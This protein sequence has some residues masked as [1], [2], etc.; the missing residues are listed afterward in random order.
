M[1]ENTP[2]EQLK[3]VGRKTARI[4]ATEKLTGQAIYV[5]DMT[6]S[7][8]LYA[9]VKTSPHAR[10]KIVKI[11]TSAAE[12]LPGVRAVIT[13]DELEYKLGL[14]VVDKDI[15]AKGVVRHYGEAV[16]AVADPLRAPLP[17]AAVL[18]VL[19]PQLVAPGAL[20][21]GGVQAVPG[22]YRVRQ[23]G[24]Q[25]VAAACSGG[26][27]HQSVLSLPKISAEQISTMGPALTKLTSQFGTGLGESPRIW[28][29]AS[30]TRPRPCI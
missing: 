28:R 14:Y 25:H 20:P 13:G 6:M 11:D 30:T 7:G 22:R 15:L 27:G 5:S 29:A 1:L 23:P 26:V 21:V 9:R 10:A 19:H 24:R 17:G 16:A 12:A 4:D 8:M 3:Q 18:A 2:V